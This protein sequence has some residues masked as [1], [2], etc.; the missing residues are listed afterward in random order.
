MHAGCSV[1]DGHIQQFCWLVQHHGASRWGL[2]GRSTSCMPG[3]DDESQSM[4]QS[5]RVS[6]GTHSCW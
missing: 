2:Q 6:E 5:G 4:F 1:V 3:T